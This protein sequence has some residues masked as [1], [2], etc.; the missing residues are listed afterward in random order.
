MGLGSKRS[1]RPKHIFDFCCADPRSHE[2]ERQ[3]ILDRLARTNWMWCHVV[4]LDHHQLYDFRA[5]FVR[6]TTPRYHT[7]VPALVIQTENLPHQCSD[8][9]SQR[10]DLHVCPAESLRFKELLPEAEGLVIRTYTTV[11]QYMVEAAPKLRVVGRAGAGIDNIDLESCKE[12]NVRVVH[13]PDA[14]SEAVVEF[15]IAMMMPKLRPIEQVVGA[16]DL[17]Q[18]SQLRENAMCHFQFNEMT[19]GI[20]GFGRIGRRLGCIAQSIGFRVLFHDI[21]NIEESYG[22]EP[23][24][25]DTLLGDSH[26]VSVH[27]DGRKENKH[28]CDAAFF[29]KMKSGAVFINTSRGFVADSQALANHLSLDP[30]SSAVLDVHDPEPIEATCPLLGLHNVSLYPH[31]ACKTQT[32]TV[33]MGWVVKDVD[34]VLS[35]ETPEFE[36]LL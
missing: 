36:A 26:V 5:S 11:D 35:G 29:S 12:H 33:N 30:K 25:L 6:V 32:A 24:N 3:R 23:S 19:L 28:L 8:W 34:A 15:V 2:G 27:V 17:A 10:C 31:A 21:Q 14:N 1:L 16:M 22:C 13:T 9:L 7:K 18:W 4:Q 20:V